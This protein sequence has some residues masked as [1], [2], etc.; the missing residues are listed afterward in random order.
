MYPTDDFYNAYQTNKP[1]WLAL[2]VLGIFV[3]TGISFLIYDLFVRREFM[4]KKD[5]LEAKRR[6]MRFVSHEVRTPLNAVC[7]GLDVMQCEMD[8][9]L[10]SVFGCLN[11]TSKNNNA[12]A[13][14]DNIT[15]ATDCLSMLQDVRLSAQ[16]AVDVLNTMLNYDKVE[17]NAL[18]LDVSILPMWS[19]VCNVVKEFTLS[20]TNKKI[21]LT[22]KVLETDQ[23]TNGSNDNDYGQHH[24]LESGTTP[25]GGEGVASQMTTALDRLAPDAQEVCVLGDAPRLKQVLRNLISNAIKFTHE[26]GTVEIEAVISRTRR[27][28]EWQALS[29]RSDARVRRFGNV[30]LTVRDTGVGMTQEQLA[31]VFREGS[32]FNVNELQNIQ[33]SGLGMYISKEIMERHQG[34]LQAESDGLGQGTTF[35][36]NLPLYLA[37]TPARNSDS[38]SRLPETGSLLSTASFHQAKTATTS[39]TSTKV[40]PEGSENTASSGPTQKESSLQNNN[41]N[42]STTPLPNQEPTRTRKGAD[43]ARTDSSAE[44]PPPASLK[45]LLVDDVSSNRKLLRRL[46]ERQGHSC[47]EA[48]NGQLAVDLYQNSPVGTFDTILMDYEMPVMNGPTAVQTLRDLGCDLVIIGVTGNM[49]PEDVDYFEACGANAVVPKPLRW[50]ELLE[51][52]HDFGLTRRKA[53]KS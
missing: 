8:T 11:N 16:S 2:G 26:N 32:R 21:V 9:E 34:S 39:T 1:I 48:E 17:Q 3:I 18:S 30:R 36:V 41:N 13:P 23:H 20:A 35:I 46:L 29:S 31:K 50:P 52:W 49:L 12:T 47:E 42:G 37:E 43:S 22:W 25:G 14:R 7:M 51:L 40:G 19:L 45:I 15:V 27:P 53:N 10:A 38:S 33:G 28:W 5:L 6:F 44:D 4:V 24:D